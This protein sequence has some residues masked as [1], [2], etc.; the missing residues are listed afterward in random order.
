MSV[1]EDEPPPQKRKKK[2]DSGVG[3]HSRLP[4]RSPVLTVLHPQAKTKVRHACGVAADITLADRSHEQ[5]EK[6]AATKGRKRKEGAKEISKDEET[7]KRLKVSSVP[8]PIRLRS[9]PSTRTPFAH[10]SSLAAVS[11]RGVRR[12]QGVGEGVQGRR[13]AVRPDPPPAPDPGRPRDEG[14]HEPGAG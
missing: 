4:L 8:S 2:A 9:S 13:P 7:I 5:A 14:P 3:V 10:V 6:G 1:L 11:S 12:A